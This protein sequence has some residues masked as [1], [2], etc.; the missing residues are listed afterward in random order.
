VAATLWTDD[1]ATA[2]ARAAL[3]DDTADV[4]SL[5]VAPLGYRVINAVTDELVRARGETTDGRR[6]SAVG[7]VLRRGAVDSTHVGSH[8]SASDDPR[9]WNYWRREALAYAGGVAARRLAPGLRAPR[10]LLLRETPDIARLWIEDV[11]GSPG[12]ELPPDRIREL[13]YA[14]GHWQGGTAAR[15]TPD[16][17]WLS[18]GW[19]AAFVP[20]ADAVEPY[21]DPT[22]PLWSHPIVRGHLT[23]ADARALRRLWDGRGVLLDALERCPS[24]VAHLDVWAAN[25]ID[26]GRDVVLLDWSSVGEAPLGADLANLVNDSVWMLQWPADRLAALD[27]ELAD[28]YVAGVADGGWR[29]DERLVRLAYAATVALHFAPLA[30]ALDRL[31][32]DDAWR[33][34]V[35]RDFG[36][37]PDDALDRRATVVAAAVEKVDGAL[38]LPALVSG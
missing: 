28:A 31:A 14:I 37:D 23:A 12:R 32:G 4:A 36:V 19:M 24:T 15:G 3:D 6:W 13:A 34:R 30:A 7:K 22:A 29:G 9:H 2:L 33:A 35:A 25:L 5:D 21:L 27:V 38:A 18:R 1:D 10:V 8:F 11:A 16:L 20:A 26:D 17:P